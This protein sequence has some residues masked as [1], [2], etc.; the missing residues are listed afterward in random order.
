MA[1]LMVAEKQFKDRS[2]AGSYDVGPNESDC[3]ETGQ[4]VTLF[5]E[6][7]NEVMGTNIAWENVNDGGPHEANFLKLDCSKIK[8][9]FDW[10]PRWDI[11][12]AIRKT[13]EWNYVFV[14]DGEIRK[15]INRQIEEHYHA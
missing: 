13:I 3:L 11:K 8:R 14:S 12:T 2:L 4:V 15:C 7:W 9:I 6:Q 10:K 5:C 1:Y